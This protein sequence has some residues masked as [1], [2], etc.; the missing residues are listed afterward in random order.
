MA[1]QFRPGRVG[2]VWRIV[3]GG[4]LLSLTGVFVQ[5]ADVEATRSAFLRNVYALPLLL[6]IVWYRARREGRGLAS[7][8]IAPIAA[9]GLLEGLEVV[10]YHAAVSA[11]GVGPAT[12]LASMQVLFVVG[13]A[14]LAFGERPGRRFWF[15]LPVALVGVALINVPSGSR[16]GAGSWY[17]TA[18]GLGAAALYASYLVGLRAVRQRYDQV[19]TPTI[20]LSATLGIVTA[21]AAAATTTGTAQPPPSAAAN[22]W[23]LALAVNTPVLAWWLITDALPQLPATATSLLLLLQPTLAIVWGMVLFGEA[24][25]T[26]RIAGL[27]L[28]LAATAVVAADS[29]RPSPPPTTSTTER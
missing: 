2:A 20:L 29:N 23:L 15:A 16:G 10:A 4:A 13:L 26:A 18:I 8:F 19:T 5:L 6:T 25:T 21:V 1:S 14:R 11:V 3:L 28:A 12:V 27:A 9:L 22:L 24:A 17:G 7:L